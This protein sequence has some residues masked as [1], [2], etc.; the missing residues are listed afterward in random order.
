M[1]KLR[2]RREEDLALHMRENQAQANPRRVLKKNCV[3]Y[4]DERLQSPM[5]SKC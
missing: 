3:W 5:L 4:C 1:H 2:Y